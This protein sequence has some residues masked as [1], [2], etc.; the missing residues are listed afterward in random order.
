MLIYCFALFS[1][2]WLDEF[3]AARGEVMLTIALLQIGMGVFSPFVGRAN[4]LGL[5]PA[6]QLSRQ[7]QLRSGR[8]VT[9]VQT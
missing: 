2:Q 1:V 5:R 4:L 8:D 3:S 7:R 9:P 6:G